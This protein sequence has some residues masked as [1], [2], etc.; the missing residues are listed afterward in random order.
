MSQ[1]QYTSV[2]IYENSKPVGVLS[3][4]DI[5]VWLESSKQEI[6]IY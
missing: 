6:V 5:S 1:K 2:V 4:S 3:A